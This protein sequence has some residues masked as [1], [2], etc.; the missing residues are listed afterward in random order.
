MAVG[1]AVTLRTIG[2]KLIEWLAKNGTTALDGMLK[3]QSRRAW[4]TYA[5]AT[6]TGTAGNITKDEIPALCHMASEIADEMVR[7]EAE[8]AEAEDDA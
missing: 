6:L 5:A 3:S 4:R 2:P 7:R 1:M 8:R